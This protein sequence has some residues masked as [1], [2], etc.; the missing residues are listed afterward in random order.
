M[1][2][3]TIPTPNTIYLCVGFFNFFFF[4][5]LLLLQ[6]YII[7]YNIK[8]FNINHHQSASSFFLVCIICRWYTMYDKFVHNE[9]FF[10][11][12]EPIYFMQNFDWFNIYHNKMLQDA[13]KT[14]VRRNFFDEE[15]VMS[16]YWLNFFTITF[17][18]FNLWL[19]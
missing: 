8:V 11:K 2:W 1:L 13:V 14:S 5:Q 3:I 18:N 19:F 7:I 12:F 16:I 17:S 6:P 4:L 15:W 10:F 9:Y